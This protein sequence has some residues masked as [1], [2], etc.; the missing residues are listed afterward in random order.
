M[1]IEALRTV[2]NVKL[3]ISD[4]INEKML[5]TY[6]KNEDNEEQ[7]GIGRLTP[8]EKEIF[9]CVGQGLTT[10]K[11][12]EQFTLSP[13]T[14]EVHRAR[15]KKKLNCESAAEVFRTAVQWVENNT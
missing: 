11:I 14:V 10:R 1:L 9:E 15:I 2:L 7:S 8:R 4:A 6:V 3:F 13:R 12:A 5:R